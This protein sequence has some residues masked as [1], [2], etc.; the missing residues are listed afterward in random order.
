MY[1][2]RCAEHAAASGYVQTIQTLFRYVRMHPDFKDD[3]AS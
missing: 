1:R 3:A 2:Y